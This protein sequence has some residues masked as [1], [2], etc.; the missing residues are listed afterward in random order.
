MIKPAEP[1]ALS[2]CLV[3]TLAVAFVA[4]V[5]AAILMFWGAIL[6]AIGAGAYWAFKLLAG[7]FA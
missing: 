1:S 4:A 7:V 2:G 5:F 3:V 6:G